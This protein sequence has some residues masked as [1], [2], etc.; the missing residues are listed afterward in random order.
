M[1][2]WIKSPKRHGI[3]DLHSYSGGRYVH[4]L[5]HLHVWLPVPVR[6]AKQQQGRAAA[7]RIPHRC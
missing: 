7:L 6:V 3:N 2:L 4:E 1:W 5:D